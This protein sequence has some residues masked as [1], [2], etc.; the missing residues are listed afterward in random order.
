VID[1]I[2]EAIDHVAEAKFASRKQ[3]I[4]DRSLI[5]MFMAEGA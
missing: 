1:D 5:A 3:S 4:V 2:A